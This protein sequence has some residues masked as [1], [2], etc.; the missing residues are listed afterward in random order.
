MA[1]IG[2]PG[3]EWMNEPG[4]STSILHSHPTLKCAQKGSE[5]RSWISP[6]YR[7]FIHV[8]Y[9]PADQYRPYHY[10]YLQ[11]KTSFTQKPYNRL[12]WKKMLCGFLMMY[13]RNDQLLVVIQIQIWI[14]DPDS[15]MN[16]SL[17]L[18]LS[19]CDH[20]Y[21]K[22]AWPICIKLAVWP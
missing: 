5:F 8:V 15:C 12:K 14:P 20:L 18:S 7:C 3:Y 1:Y 19:L 13:G 9:S 6:L 21:S 2:R 16:V 11:N 10:R 22:T 17:L 4:Q